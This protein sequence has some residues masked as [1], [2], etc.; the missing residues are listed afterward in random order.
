[1]D[2]PGAKKGRQLAQVNASKPIILNHAMIALLADVQ[3]KRMLAQT[4]TTK[5]LHDCRPELSLSAEAGPGQATVLRR[6]IRA[7]LAGR[8]A[9]GLAYQT[10]VVLGTE[11]GHT[12][13]ISD[14]D[15]REHQDQVPAGRGGDEGRAPTQTTSREHQVSRPFW[16]KR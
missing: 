2:R 10:P 7:L 1:M 15:G 16:T 3:A 14:S 9:K 8:H 13:R 12:D 6:G 5:R 4:L 11:L